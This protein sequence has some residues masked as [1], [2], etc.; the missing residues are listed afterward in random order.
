VANSPV[1]SRED[2]NLELA[3][4]RGATGARRRWWLMAPLAALLALWWSGALEN[5]RA[6]APTQK[7][8]LLV[9]PRSEV[10]ASSE[11]DEKAQDSGVR[12][13][14]PL[15]GSTDTSL[16]LIRPGTAVV[17]GRVV[18][19]SGEP[20][21]DVE[22]QLEVLMDFA[23][24]HVGANSVPPSA[25]LQSTTTTDANGHFGFDSLPAYGQELDARFEREGWA[26]ER[27]VFAAP[28]GGVLDL[29][30]VTLRRGAPV[31][32]AVLDEAGARVP[33]VNVY[34]ARDSHVWRLTGTLGE[35]AG[36]ANTNGEFTTG[37]LA[38]GAY[39]FCA[40]HDDFVSEWSAPVHIAS[41]VAPATVTLRGWWGVTVDGKVLDMASGAPLQADVTFAPFAG[42][43]GHHAT[44]RADG[45]FQMR[46]CRVGSTYTFVASAPGYTTN[47]GVNAHTVL[48]PVEGEA[49]LTIQLRKL[50]TRQLQVVDAATGNPVVQAEVRSGFVPNGLARSFLFHAEFLAAAP[51]LARTG[52]DG[53]ASVIEPAHSALV[54]VTAA[55]YSP[56]LL[57]LAREKS[58]PESASASD[59]VVRCA[60]ARGV[61][62]RVELRGDA[63][64]GQIVGP[65][66]VELRAARRPLQRT[67][68]FADEDAVAPAPVL[69]TVTLHDS[70]LAE[71]A[72]VAAGEFEVAA[73]SASGRVAIG[74]VSVNGTDDA[75]VVLNTA[76]AASVLARVHGF[77]APHLRRDV[78]F[79][80]LLTDRAG[81]VRRAFVQAGVSCQFAGLSPGAAVLALSTT[82]HP[83]LTTGTESDG[84]YTISKEYV[85][86]NAGLNEFDL[87]A[88][89]FL[90]SLT[91]VVLTNGQAAP[92]LDVSAFAVPTPRE[93]RFLARTATDDNGRFELSPIPPGPYRI[94][95]SDTSF[96]AGDVRLADQI[97]VVEPLVSRTVTIEVESGSLRLSAGT[98]AARASLRF[99][100]VSIANDVDPSTGATP[101]FTSD[102]QLDGNAAAHVR[103]MRTGNYLLLLPGRDAAAD[104]RFSIAPGECT[105]VT[106]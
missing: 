17:R 68:A 60:L 24:Q 34:V 104:V 101:V 49:Q 22:V 4:V 26:P 12:Q 3:R 46:G 38:H 71:F 27:L 48:A 16:E 77:S 72:D 95:V 85:E 23:D 96:R 83:W 14:V 7:S 5:R 10:E 93:Q 51:I 94:I 33:G 41:D 32:G 1:S 8:T 6:Q 21:A 63:P 90:A 28:W 91:G 106:L 35:L 53:L 40:E 75:F 82:T 98:D 19:P 69:R 78:R 58:D 36:V 65:W 37:P 50:A 43:R 15:V 61:R 52:S 62:V 92:G 54:C 42:L 59:S 44:T 57:L 103:R 31:R 11:L 76:A 29:G 81:A 88:T 74:K 45:S 97:C 30:D 64:N 18:N 79:Q 105:N 87:R 39:R 89:E 73:L 67:P 2:G 9:E 25:A 100:V 66:K 55:G 70:A 86:L 102:L 47:T 56:Q 20:M 84:A 99:Q 13:S 80:V